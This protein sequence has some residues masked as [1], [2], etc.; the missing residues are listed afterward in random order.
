MV[1]DTPPRLRG[2]V[3]PV[4]VAGATEKDPVIVPQAPNASFGVKLAPL[5]TAAICGAGPLAAAVPVPS[6][7][8]GENKLVEPFAVRVSEAA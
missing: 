8:T 5:T 7:L 2:S 4:A 1:T 6:K 3:D